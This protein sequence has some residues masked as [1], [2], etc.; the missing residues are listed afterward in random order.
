MNNEYL[1]HWFYISVEIHLVYYYYYYYACYL[2]FQ[3]HS[4]ICYFLLKLC[5]FVRV[6]QCLVLQN[7]QPFVV[8]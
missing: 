1:L 4:L 5:T 8:S 7:I 6:S 3:L 2:F